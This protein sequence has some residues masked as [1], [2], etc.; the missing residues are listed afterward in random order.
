[1]ATFIIGQRKPKQL[2]QYKPLSKASVTPA[3]HVAA[4]GTTANIVATQYWVVSKAF[5]PKL[6]GYN[7]SCTATNGKVYGIFATYAK[8]LQYCNNHPKWYYYMAIVGMP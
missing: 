4:N 7:K 6:Q 3:H 5:A 2:A 8:A 1:M